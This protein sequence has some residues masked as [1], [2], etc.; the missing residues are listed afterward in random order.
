MNSITRNTFFCWSIRECGRQQI[1]LCEPDSRHDAET[2]PTSRPRVPTDCLQIASQPRKITWIGYIGRGTVS[3]IVTLEFLSSPHYSQTQYSS[4][5]P[6]S[7]SQSIGTKFEIVEQTLIF[8]YPGQ[9]EQSKL[10]VH[11]NNLIRTPSSRLA[12]ENLKIKIHTKYLSSVVLY[13]CETWSLTLREK[14]EQTPIVF[15]ENE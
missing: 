14:I 15:K 9:C 2:T 13:G 1:V 5:P 7:S 4:F 12:P 10:N 11:T 3:D 8:K 6:L